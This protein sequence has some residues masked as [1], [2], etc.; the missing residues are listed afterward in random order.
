MKA[1]SIKNPKVNKY[2]HTDWM[3]EDEL[4]LQIEGLNMDAVWD[5]FIIQVGG[6]ELEQGNDLAEQIELDDLKTKDLLTDDGVIFIS[7]DDNEVF[8]LKKICDEIF[9]SANFVVQFAVQL[10]PR[11][12]N[13]DLFVAKTHES[14]LVYAKNYLQPTTMFGV[15]KEG[16]MVEEYNKQD[17]VGKYRAIG[18]RN[19]NQSFNP[20][21]RPNLYFPLYV[22]PKT[23]KVSTE[24]DGTYT[25]EVWP[26]APDGTKTCWTAD[27]HI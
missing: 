21:T 27:W 6:V 8:N 19:R 9:G 26:D 3:S 10:N 7:I 5:N 4:I 2:Y 17:E 25:D 14:V 1:I 24:K 18:L 16:K 11:G 12:R 20:Q 22:D 13:L 15:E 23:H